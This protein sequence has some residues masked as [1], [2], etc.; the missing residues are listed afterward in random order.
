MRKI[1]I[2]GNMNNLG[3]IWLRYLIDAGCDADLFLYS[4]DGSDGLAHFA[5]DFQNHQGIARSVHPTKIKNS[6]RSAHFV[7][8][9]IGLL[10]ERKMN[11]LGFVRDVRQLRIDR[12]RLL[13]YDLIITMG[14][15]PLFL[16]RYGRAVDLFYPYA[17]GVDNVGTINVDELIKNSSLI[18]RLIGKF[19]QKR[20]VAALKKS[21]VNLTS[22]KGINVQVYNA[23]CIPHKVAVMPSVYLRHDLKKS[24]PIAKAELNLV[25]HGRHYWVN[26]E[27]FEPDQWVSRSKNTDFI[28]KAL[29]I[30]KDKR[31]CS[32]VRL[33]LVEYGKDVDRTKDLIIELGLSE[34]VKWVPVLEEKQLQELISGCDAGIGEFYQT[35][36]TFWGCAGWE[37]LGAGKPLIQGGK[38]TDLSEREY[39]EKGVLLAN[40]PEEIAE[41]MLR[42][43]DSPG[44]AAEL[45]VK[46][47]GYFETSHS[48]KHIIELLL[49]VEPA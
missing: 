15:G 27:C 41:H 36:N 42:L 29:R 48:G 13:S 11:L 2:L 1:A 45:G 26:D 23:H 14:V 49:G 10:Y 47:R 38:L 7:F 33:T 32:N 21:R 12:A 4:N 28:I 16:M 35:E 46:A 25:F 43:F 17:I 39:S 20:Q 31:P 44:L 22:D 8:E 37:V 24:Q 3:F 30:F 9:M 6:L 19:V 40:N 5:P 18:K 34:I